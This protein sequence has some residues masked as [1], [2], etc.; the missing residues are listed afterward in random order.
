MH[1][2]I[3]IYICTYRHTCMYM[4]TKARQPCMHIQIHTYM[5][6]Y[7]HMLTHTYIHTHS[8]HACTGTQTHVQTGRH[9]PAYRDT[10][11][12]IYIHISMHTTYLNAHIYKHIFGWSIFNHPCILS[13]SVLLCDSFENFFLLMS[14]LY[15]YLL[16]GHIWSWSY[17]FLFLDTALWSFLNFFTF[18][19]FDIRMCLTEDILD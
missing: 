16:V 2:H 7:M 9:R 1:I 13:F 10:Q 11:A 8:S 3:Y 15:L 17:F 18:N 4:H 19:I 5:P 12:H 6:T 14:D